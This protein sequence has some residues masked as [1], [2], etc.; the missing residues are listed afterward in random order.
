MAAVPAVLQNALGVRTWGDVRAMIHSGGPAISS[1]LVGWNV[2]D[3]NKASLIAGLLVALASPLA[4]Y[5]EAE[6]N[7]RKWLYGVVAAVQAVLIGVVGVVD[8]PI[9]DL[10]GSALAILGGM[11]ASAN[12]PTSESG[13][14][15]TSSNAVNS[16]DAH[17]A[18][19]TR[20]IQQP[21]SVDTSSIRAAT[22]TANIPN[23]GWRGL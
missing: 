18:S 15:A 22:K 8:S 1:L 12:T 20:R 17:K 6:N 21:V 4:A 11:V 23:T 9:V 7:F 19:Q 2:V 16:T 13:F 10:L 14:V 3:D 5:P